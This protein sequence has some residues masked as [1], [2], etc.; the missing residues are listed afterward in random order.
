MDLHRVRR[1][2]DVLVTS[3][4]RSGRSASDPRS[5]FGR[6]SFIAF[7]D[8]AL[9]AV[10]FA[11][12]E[13]VVQGAGSSLGSVNAL[14]LAFLPLVPLIA[15]AAV[16]VAGVMFELTATTKFSASDAANWMPLEPGEYVAASS[17][18]IAYT[19]SPA[20]VL[21]LGVTLPF[22]LA[23]GVLG[24]WLLALL[25]AVVSLFEGAFL[26]EMVR[27]ATQRASSVSVGRRGHLT[28]ILRA[29]LLI[30]VILSLQLAFNPIFLIAVIGDVGRL[31]LVTAVVPFFWGTEALVYASSGS[32]LV[33]VG[34]A[35]GLV[36]FTAVL[37]ALAMRLRSQYW[38]VSGTEIRLDAIDYAAGHPF[39]HALGLGAPEAAI[40]SKDLRGYTRRRELLP[41]L[42]V[43]VILIVLI[44]VEGHR[45]G[46]LGAIVWAGWVA[47]FFALMLSVS[48]IGQE[49][50]ALQSLFSFPLTPRNVLRAKST[51]VLLPSIVAAI[52]V[53]SAVGVI[54]GLAA[55]EI[56]GL[57]L[58]IVGGTVVLAFWGLV[59][60]ARFSDF[61][62][63]PRPQFLRPSAMLA[64]MGSGMVVLFAILVPGAVALA[65]PGFGGTSPAIAAV[66]I[67]LGVGLS[68]AHWARTGF[69][70]LFRE[71][72]F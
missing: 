50:R 37:L 41:L 59:F 57:L 55:P 39:L 29:V 16:L 52:V 10:T 38:V 43:P 33:A 47:G 58:L 31:G 2:A 44:V 21:F 17:V 68:A 69:D 1:L 13:F 26:V 40:V 56:A 67:A 62:D 4:L 19:Y 14:V 23:A 61:Q 7:A 25:L 63:R 5:F 71:L 28:L 49:R 24:V 9:F 72:P 3:Q 8:A 11:I 27:A 51:A 53:T 30:V 66:V 22:A 35:I 45:I 6:S 64:A 34:F 20:I 42:V 65:A 54:F 15:V 48:S 60:A 12:A 18:A 46:T 70:Q 32:F 36:A